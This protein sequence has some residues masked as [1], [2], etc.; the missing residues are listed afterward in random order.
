MKSTK[1]AETET[2]TTKIENSMFQYFIVF[3]LP[4]KIK[5]H[6]HLLKSTRY[7]RNN[8]KSK[9]QSNIHNISHCNTKSQK[10]VRFINEPHIKTMHV[11]QFAYIQARKDKW[12]QAG[13]DR[14][15]FEKR[16]DEFERIISPILK[17]KYEKI[18]KNI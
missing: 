16:I 18:I 1:M 17:K 12:Q 13:R 6:S 14:S 15:R 11:W 10:S 2:K 3:H 9:N 4:E 7:F 8:T 5:I